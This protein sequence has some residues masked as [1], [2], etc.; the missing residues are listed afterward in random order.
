MNISCHPK[1]PTF[2]LQTKQN[3]PIF[4][5]FI[6]PQPNRIWFLTRQRHFG[7][8]IVLKRSKSNSN[9]IHLVIYMGPPYF[10]TKVVTSSQVPSRNC[11]GRKALNSTTH[12]TS[13]IP[14]KEYATNNRTSMFETFFAEKYK[15]SI[16]GRGSQYIW[17]GGGRGERGIYFYQNN[18][19]LIFTI[20]I[21]GVG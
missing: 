1:D 19:W 11:F 9:S 12:T 3:L 21:I 6:V 20:H 16:V 5:V 15:Q 17:P 4:H 14:I 8:C 18:F 7:I 2:K 13:L 10:L